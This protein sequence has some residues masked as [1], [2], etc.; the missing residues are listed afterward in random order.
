MN[1]AILGASDKSERY[2]YKAFKMLQEYGHNVFPVHPRLDE[3][4]GVKVF[5]SLKKISEKID[6]LTMYVGEARSQ[7]LIDDVLRLHPDRIIFNPGAENAS[8]EQR[9]TEAGIVCI[10]GCTLVM[11]STGQF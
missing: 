2:A 10:N 5:S 7:G 1:V 8:L 4:Q 11:L 9:A 3:V 6:T